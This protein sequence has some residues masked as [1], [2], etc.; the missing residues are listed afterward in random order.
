MN[1]PLAVDLFV[2]DRA[3]EEFLNDPRH[4]GARAVR[5]AAMLARLPS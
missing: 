2:E 3:H 5:Q 1:E 4:V